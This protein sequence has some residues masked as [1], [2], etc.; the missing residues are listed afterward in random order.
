LHPTTQENNMATSN[1][2]LTPDPATEI[3][4]PKGLVPL[5]DDRETL[6]YDPPETI[7]PAENIELDEDDALFAK[8]SG[9]KGGH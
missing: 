3:D 8:R 5:D 1:S 9:I 2:P 4:S 6:E 7:E